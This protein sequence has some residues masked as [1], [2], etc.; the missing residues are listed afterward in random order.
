H[1]PS[2]SPAG[3]TGLSS[4][5]ET[6]PARLTWSLAPHSPAERMAA[7]KGGL[8]PSPE[9]AARAGPRQ[10]LHLSRTMLSDQWSPY[11]GRFACDWHRLPRDVLPGNHRPRLK[12]SR[13]IA[14]GRDA[15][16]E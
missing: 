7:P 2:P 6:G 12:P 13:I 10:G 3:S 15:S 11:V 14:T 1:R 8:A 9:P 5:S 4:C 16:A